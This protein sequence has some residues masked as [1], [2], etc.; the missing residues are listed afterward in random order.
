MTVLVK[1]AA[2]VDETTT[3]CRMFAA[4]TDVP[5]LLSQYLLKGKTIGEVDPGCGVLLRQGHVTSNG[6]VPD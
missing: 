6:I 5:L 2:E 1:P 4:G 3:T